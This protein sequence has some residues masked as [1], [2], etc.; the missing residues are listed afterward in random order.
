MRKTIAALIRIGACLCIMGGTALSETVDKPVP[1][2]VAVTP[3]TVYKFEAVPEGKEIL[4]DFLVRNGGSE[5]LI[6]QNIKAG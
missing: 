1:G 3:E 5:E 2:P 4:H 6:I